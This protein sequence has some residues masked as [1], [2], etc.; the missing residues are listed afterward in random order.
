M[1]HLYRVCSLFLLVM[2]VAVGVH[3]IITPLYDDGSTGFPVWSVF[4]WPMA[5]A[6][7]FA[8]SKNLFEWVRRFGG[9]VESEGVIQW[10]QTNFRFYSSLVLLLWFF[11]NWFADLLSLDPGIRWA[12]VDALFVAVM[13]ST[14]LHPWHEEQRQE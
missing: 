7:V 10:L 11:N 12:F 5:V 13:L 14:G 3:Y 6:V 1:A 2:A 8:F 9:S 4:D